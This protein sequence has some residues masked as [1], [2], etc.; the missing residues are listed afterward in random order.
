MRKF[1]AIVAVALSLGGCA[2]FKAITG[3]ISIGTA[4]IDNPIT[5]AREAQIEAAIDAGV[6]ALLVYR[7]A[8]LA[9]SADVNCRQN[10]RLAQPY[11]I[12][13]KKLV[14]RLRTFVDS[15]DQVNAIVVFKQIVPLYEEMK[16]IA[17]TAG[18]NIGAL[19]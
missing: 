13:L 18:V 1:L 10:I 17:A 6:Q 7:R 16:S 5:A 19:P 4:S 3:A 2:E 14:V 9:G 12:Q 8:C 15:N 11:T